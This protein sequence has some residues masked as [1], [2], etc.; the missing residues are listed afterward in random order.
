M[1]RYSIGISPDLDGLMDP[2]QR[3]PAGWCPACGSEIWEEGKGLCVRCERRSGTEPLVKQFQRTYI[4]TA[5]TP[6]Q[7]GLRD[8]LE[9][10]HYQFREEATADV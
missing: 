2:Q 6:M 4:V 7:R 1:S 3:P 10:R 8:W 5:S 9:S